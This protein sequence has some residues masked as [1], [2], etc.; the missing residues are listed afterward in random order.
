[1]KDFAPLVL[2][3]VPG[4]VIPIKPDKFRRVRN[5]V[6]NEVLKEYP[7]MLIS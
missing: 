5:I 6:N 7:G 1:M 2:V 3:L 4:A